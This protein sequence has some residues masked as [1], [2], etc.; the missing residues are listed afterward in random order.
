[1]KKQIAAIIAAL[2]LA[3][4]PMTAAS[5]FDT[6][7]NGHLWDISESAF[8]I[9]ELDNDDVFD[10]SSLALSI[11]AGS[12]YTTYD[13]RDAAVMSE[14][15]IGSAKAVTCDELVT[16]VEGLN[17]R[18]YAYVYPDGL[19]TAVTY[20]IT[21]TTGSA[22]NFQWKQYHNYGNGVISDSDYA[23]IY[24]I[25]DG[26]VN[27]SAPASIAWGPTTQACS[28]ASGVDNGDDQ[29]EV[30]SESC[31]VAA[32]ATTAITIYH[33]SDSIGAL[34]NLTTNSNSFFVTRSADATLVQGIPS[35]L[36]AA[37]WGLTGTMTTTNI[38]EASD[39]WDATETMTLTG[40]AVLGSPM[41]IAFKNGAD[42]VGTYYDV[43]MCPN[44]DVKPV[45]EVNEGDCF[46]VTFWNRADV[47]SYN[48]NTTALTMTW[49]LANEQVPGLQSVGG[50]P[51]LDSNGDPVLMDPPTEEG[52]WCAYE[53]WYIIV[54]D[55][56]GGAHSN[57]SPAL[58]AAGCSEAAALADTGV[59]AQS[60]GLV[61]VFALMG[62]LGVAVAM[63]RRSA[64]SL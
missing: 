21:N 26:T 62:G 45:D 16:V 56:D 29:M 38:P 35:G 33:M 5:A 2:G 25:N 4:A 6:T 12:N 11:D 63:R 57:W 60:I 47:A 20:A 42:P 23:D 32:G 59:D 28:A 37:N 27:P 52:G 30:E 24:S 58:G 53:G 49:T 17:V 19:L 18:G 3:L 9:N 8:G 22:I 40:D 14:T 13:C 34:A 43:W 54:N 1:M 50:N 10:E 48:Q 64:R 36:V 51:Y 55:Y 7:V 46:A 61:G 41:T 31:T 15:V 44:Q 39:P